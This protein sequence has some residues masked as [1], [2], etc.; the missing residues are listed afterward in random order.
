MS[1]LSV[2]FY[3]SR[4]IQR[5]PEQYFTLNAAALDVF[6]LFYFYQFLFDVL[7]PP[8]YKTIHKPLQMYSGRPSTGGVYVPY[9]LHT[10]KYLLLV[11][12]YQKCSL[13]ENVARTK[14]MLQHLFL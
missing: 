11:E 5:T 10:F 13:Y 8:G 3:H 14:N 4:S 1:E 9:L 2:H 6:D 12:L 7:I